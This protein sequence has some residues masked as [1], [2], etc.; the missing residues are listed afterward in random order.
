LSEHT[1]RDFDNSAAG[2]APLPDCTIWLL[3]G[4]EGLLR[5]QFLDR[6]LLSLLTAEERGWG[7]ETLR[8]TP[9]LVRANPPE[10]SWAKHITNLAAALPFFSSKRVVVVDEAQHLPPDQQ[11]VLAEA[12]GSLSQNSVLILTSPETAGAQRGKAVAAKKPPAK[13]R[14]STKTKAAAKG[15]LSADLCKAINQ[16]GAVVHF[17]PLKSDEAVAWVINEARKSGKKMEPSAAGFLVTQRIGPDLGALQREVDKLVL[18][19]ANEPTIKISHV[20]EMTPRTLEDSVFELTKALEQGRAGQQRVLI[21]LRRMLQEKVEPMRILPIL[22]RHYRFIWQAKG[23]LEKGWRIG[24]PIKEAAAFE[25]VVLHEKDSLAAIP[26]QNSW[27]IEKAANQAR[28]LTWPQLA[29]ILTAL[30]EC[31]LALKGLSS[32]PRTDPALALELAVISL[33]TELVKETAD[34]RR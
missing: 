28:R 1:W 31:D 12:L 30:A 22:T 26:P 27:Q 29:K 20:Q 9:A 7:L 3:A 16:L 19:A 5:R 11:T 4:K 23:L 33:C 10:G 8:L 34:L 17:A 13:S 14:A 25:S 2:K 21:L 18:F 6:L 15:K 24:Q 32:P